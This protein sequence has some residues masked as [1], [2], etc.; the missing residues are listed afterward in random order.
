MYFFRKLIILITIISYVHLF[1]FPPLPLPLSCLQVVC[2]VLEFLNKCKH[3][4]GFEGNNLLF[5]VKIC[6]WLMASMDRPSGCFLVLS[7]RE[8]FHL[9][10][11][12]GRPQPTTVLGGVCVLIHFL[13]TYGRFSAAI[14]AIT[15]PAPLP[16]TNLVPPAA[17]T[18]F[19][20]PRAVSP[21][22][23][24]PSKWIGEWL[25]R[26]R[27]RYLCCGCYAAFPDACGEGEG[28]IRSPVL[29]SNW[30]KVP[31]TM[32]LRASIN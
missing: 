3:R 30:L 28:R 7:A 8:H 13:W 24:P 12:G 11:L 5:S 15:P 21:L 31:C 9:P 19:P 16:Q 26:R 25:H 4:Y 32:A 17:K 10:A 1:D 2:G 18:F 22:F 20:P 29:G 14:T 23:Q 6:S 27:D